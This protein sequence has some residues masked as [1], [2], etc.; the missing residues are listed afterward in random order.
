MAEV[1]RDG[2]HGVFLMIDVAFFGANALKIIQGGWLPLVVASLL[3]TMMTTWRTGR[4]I[5]ADRLAT[6]A[7]PLAEFFALV[8]ATGRVASVV[9]AVNMTAQGTGMPPALVL[10]LQYNKALDERW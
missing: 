10:H 9:T 1:G 7:I 6:R 3:F 2:R 4:Q 8:D 5:V